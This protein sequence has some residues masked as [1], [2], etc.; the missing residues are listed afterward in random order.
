MMATPVRL[1]VGVALALSGCGP[2]TQS[3]QVPERDA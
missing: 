3:G 2:T 1:L